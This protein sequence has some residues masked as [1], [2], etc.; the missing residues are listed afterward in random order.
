MLYYNLLTAGKLHIHLADIDEQA[1]DMFLRL[2]DQLAEHEGITEQL[3][4]ENMIEWI[5]RM[6]NIRNRA[7]EIVMHDIIMA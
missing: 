1:Q 3:K 6:N 7:S 4:A 5:G 2:V